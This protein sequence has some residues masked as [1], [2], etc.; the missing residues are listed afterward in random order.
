MLTITE[1]SDPVARVLKIVDHGTSDRNPDAR[2]VKK[3]MVA[4]I[5]A[6]ITD[7]VA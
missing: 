5:S 3:M 6:A 4:P 2:A 1:I 7:D